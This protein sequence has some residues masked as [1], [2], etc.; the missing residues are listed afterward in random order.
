MNI[1]KYFIVIKNVFFPIEKII[2]LFFFLSNKNNQ[3]KINVV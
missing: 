3:L 1:Y 2:K